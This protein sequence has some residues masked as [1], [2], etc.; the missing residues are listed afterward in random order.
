MGRGTHRRRTP[1]ENRSSNFSSDDSTHIPKPPRRPADPAQ[2]WMTFV[3]N[4]TKAIIATDFFVVVTATFRLIYVFVFM[5]LDTRRIFHFNVTQHPTA[6][7]TLQQFRECVSGDEGYRFVIHDRDRIYSQDLDQSLKSLGLTVLKTPYKS[8]Q[9]NAFCE[10]LIGSARRECF[11]FMIPLNE[12]TSD[13]RLNPGPAITIVDDLIPASDRAH[14][15]R[16]G[17]RPSFKSN[18]IAFQKAAT[19]CRFQFWVVYITN[20]GLRRLRHDSPIFTGK[21]GSI[22]CGRQALW[23]RRPII[24]LVMTSPYIRV[25][26]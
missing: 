14:Q 12:P 23:V 11:D 26:F 19:L 13:R 6:E 4:H 10:R 21:L 2:R 7:C 20:T 25:N 15:I 17:R 16:V 3:R 1:A 18:D 9:A 8:P 22:N 5:E 24:R